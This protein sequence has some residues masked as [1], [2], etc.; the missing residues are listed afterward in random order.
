MS[1]KLRYKDYQLASRPSSLKRDATVDAGSHV[2]ERSGLHEI[3]TVK[4]F[5][6]QM[7]QRGVHTWW[8]EAMGYT[9]KDDHL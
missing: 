8:R 7:E 1:K 5:G 4:E 2:V 9:G 3:D 6:V